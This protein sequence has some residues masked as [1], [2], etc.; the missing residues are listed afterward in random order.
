MLNLIIL[1]AVFST[2]NVFADPESAAREDQVD[3]HVYES[4]YR[5]SRNEKEIFLTPIGQARYLRS[6]SLPKATP[7]KSSLVLKQRFEQLRDQ[8]FLTS[9]SSPGMLRRIS[10]LYPDDGCFARAA[11][12][13]RNAFRL[14]VPIPDKIFVFGNLRVKTPFSKKGMSAGGIT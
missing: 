1:Y 14:F 9:S 5:R 11:M 12:V 6:T 10:W 13:S 8:Q 3:Y 7:W 4:N 2:A